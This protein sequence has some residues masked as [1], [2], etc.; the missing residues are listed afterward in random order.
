M[1]GS[2]PFQTCSLGMVN[3]GKNMTLKTWRGEDFTAGAFPSP[4]HVNGVFPT[5]ERHSCGP[6]MRHSPTSERELTFHTAM[7]M[8]DD[9]FDTTGCTPALLTLQGIVPT[10][11]RRKISYIEWD[12]LLNIFSSLILSVSKSNLYSLILI[13][14]KSNL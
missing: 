5:T 13:V 1:Q 2:G 7:N 10:P 11:K 4:M 14:S 9:I 3:N 6:L 12:P 8:S